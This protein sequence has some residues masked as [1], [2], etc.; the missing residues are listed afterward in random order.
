MSDSHEAMAD[1]LKAGCIFKYEV[2]VAVLCAVD[3]N[4][5]VTAA[6]LTSQINY[7]RWQHQKA[8][9]VKVKHKV[10]LAELQQTVI[11]A[12]GKIRY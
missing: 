4:K 9:N 10:N 12:E 5:K 3:F 1:H 11:R 6:I 2:C 7:Y 8:V